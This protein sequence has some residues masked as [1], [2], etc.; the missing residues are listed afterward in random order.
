M[1]AYCGEALGNGMKAYELSDYQSTGNKTTV[2][3]SVAEIMANEHVIAEIKHRNLIKQE[4]SHLS[5]EYL[6][7]KLMEIMLAEQDRNPQAALRAIELA[8][9][10]IAL[11]KERQEISGPDGEAI[12]HEQRIKESAADF[13]NKLESLARRA[14]GTDGPSGASNVVEFPN[15]RGE[16]GT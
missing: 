12:Q 10:S 4:R 7:E 2:M 1:N 15:G 11:W 14:T 3:K 5:A 6:V 16:G 13:T 9:K 8:G